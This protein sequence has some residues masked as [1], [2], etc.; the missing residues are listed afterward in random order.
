MKM[1]KYLNY[2]KTHPPQALWGFTEMM[3]SNTQHSIQAPDFYIILQY[4][5]CAFPSREM[6]S[7]CNEKQT[8]ENFS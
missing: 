7:M 2:N 3:H 4:V 8:K 1:I 6:H 5:L